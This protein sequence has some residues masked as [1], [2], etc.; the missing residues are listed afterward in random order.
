M[1]GRKIREQSPNW[2]TFCERDPEKMD[3]YSI[4]SNRTKSGNGSVWRGEATD[5]PAREYA[6][7]TKNRK[8]TRYPKSALQIFQDR[9][10]LRIDMKFFV[11]PPQMCAHRL[12]TDVKGLGDFLVVIALCKVIENFQFAFGKILRFST[13]GVPLKVFHQ[14]PRNRPG[15][16]RA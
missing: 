8:L 16:R 10:S 7:P 6:R 13:R 5:E 11:N 14:S 4:R 15:H 2:R 1:A 3:Y 9:F 12:N